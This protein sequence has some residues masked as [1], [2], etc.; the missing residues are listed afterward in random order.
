MKKAFGFLIGAT[1]GGLMGAVLALLFAPASGKEVRIQIGT[2]A[3]SFA[4][5]VR[6]AANTRRIELTERLEILRAPQE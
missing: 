6:Q 2:R 4:A 1:I 5:D 3:Q